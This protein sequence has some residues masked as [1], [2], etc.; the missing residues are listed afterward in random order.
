MVAW[1][2]GKEGGVDHVPISTMLAGRSSSSA[3]RATTGATSVS[4]P[5][6]QSLFDAPIAPSQSNATWTVALFL[7][8]A[9]SG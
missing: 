1:G 8:P 6:L 5:R 3:I 4:F 7:V 2:L 9:G